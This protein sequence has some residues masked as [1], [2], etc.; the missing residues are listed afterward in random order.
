MAENGKRK[1]RTHIP[2]KPEHPLNLWSIMK[3]CIGKVRN[4][5]LSYHY[6]I[7]IGYS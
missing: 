4:H 6:I 7:T 3:S 5:K 2:D 1:R